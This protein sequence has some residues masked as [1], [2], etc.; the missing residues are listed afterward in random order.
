MQCQFAMPFRSGIVILQAPFHCYHHESS[1]A[2][3]EAFCTADPS[4]FE[5]VGHVKFTRRAPSS[6]GGISIACFS[7][8]CVKAKRCGKCHADALRKHVELPQVTNMR[9]PWWAVSSVIGALHRTHV[10]RVTLPSSGGASIGWAGF[11]P[12][13]SFCSRT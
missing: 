2:A 12:G 10:F 7:C 6:F 11:A 3:T 13:T 8:V 1:A 4:S 5:Q 9:T